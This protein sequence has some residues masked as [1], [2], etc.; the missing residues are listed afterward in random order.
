MVEKLKQDR[1]GGT[2][3]IRPH[4]PSHA[5]HTSQIGNTRVLEVG[6]GFGLAGAKKLVELQDR[7]SQTLSEFTQRTEEVR[8]C[9]A[10]AESLPA[11][12]VKNKPISAIELLQTFE[13]KDHIYI[14]DTF[15]PAVMKKVQDE[16]PQETT[17]AKFPGRTVLKQVFSELKKV[18]DDCQRKEKK[19]NVAKR[20]LQQLT[21]SMENIGAM[22]RKAEVMCSKILEDDPVAREQKLARRNQLNRRRRDIKADKI[23]KPRPA[24]DAMEALWLMNKS[25]V[26]LYI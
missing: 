22:Q 6:V 24:D 11:D 16:H 15:L 26:M 18:E 17:D 3:A 1:V 4:V 8:V 13:H 21:K 19:H 2:W 7:V 14:T 12:L 5:V 10:F 20:C 9:T 23:K 25:Q